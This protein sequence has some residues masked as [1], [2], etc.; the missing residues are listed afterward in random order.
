[1][2]VQESSLRYLCEKREDRKI[3]KIADVI[4]SGVVGAGAG[5]GVGAAIGRDVVDR[6]IYNKISKM[7]KEPM[8]VFNKIRS[9]FYKPV[10]GD[11]FGPGVNFNII[12]KNEK[13]IERATVRVQKA[14]AK[15]VSSGTKRGLKKGLIIGGVLGLSVATIRSL[16]TMAYKARQGRLAKKK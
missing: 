6:A 1:M 5:A 10:F 4:V 11:M 3:N 13:S 8:V 7:P 2:N 15:A 16:W 12:G 14:M 9:G